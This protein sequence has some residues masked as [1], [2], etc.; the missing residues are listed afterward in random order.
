MHTCK[1]YRLGQGGVKFFGE[2]EKNFKIELEGRVRY[3]F[4][5]CVVSRLANASCVKKIS[6][7]LS[8]APFSS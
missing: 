7:L 5:A 2:G 6:D 1:S 8:D 3:H 4:E